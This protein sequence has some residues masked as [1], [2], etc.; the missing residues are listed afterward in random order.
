M[1]VE[2]HQRTMEILQ[3]IAQSIYNKK[4]YNILALDVRQFS[5]MADYVILAEGNIDRHVQ[6]LASEVQKD[7]LDIG[8][9]PWNV[10]GERSGDW[11]VLDYGD[12]VVHLLLPEFRE[13]Y[14]LEQLWRSA[15]IVD[16]KIEV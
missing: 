13:K 5:S 1:K 16:I 12:V 11:V 6:A 10:E 7:L 4:G 3:Q 8:E 15:E 14:A 9:R 2:Q